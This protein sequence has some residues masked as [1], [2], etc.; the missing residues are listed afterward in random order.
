M[1]QPLRA[2]PFESGHVWRRVVMVDV[3]IQAAP[4]RQTEGVAQPDKQPALMAVVVIQERLVPQ[5]TTLKSAK[6]SSVVNRLLSPVD[7]P[8]ATPAQHALQSVATPVVH[9]PHRPRRFQVSR[10]HL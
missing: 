6:E 10:T 7:H 3:V 5:S 2:D 1:G 8:A 4:V 9:R